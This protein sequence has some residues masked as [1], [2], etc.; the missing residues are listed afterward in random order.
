MLMDVHQRG[1][2]RF[3]QS[4]PE[5]RR[6]FPDDAALCRLPG[7]GSLERRVRLPPLSGGGRAFSFRK[8]SWRLALPQLPRHRIDG[9]NGHGGAPPPAERMVLVC[10]SDV[11][12]DTPRGV[13][14]AS[15]TTWS[16]ALRSGG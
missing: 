16:C 13:R 6:L 2:L 15:A 1:D 10:L 8:S 11:H 7:E 5:F 12:P 9:G 14:A 4:L 3:P